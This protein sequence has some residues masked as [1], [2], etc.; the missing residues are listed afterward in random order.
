MGFFTPSRG[1]NI[2]AGAKRDNRDQKSRTWE[3]LRCSHFSTLSTNSHDSFLGGV[4]SE[5]AGDAAQHSRPKTLF[6]LSFGFL[7]AASRMVA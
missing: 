5:S 6:R 3:G 7:G 2:G 1:G 4:V